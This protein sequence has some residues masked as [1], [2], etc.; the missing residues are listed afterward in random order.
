M[1]DQFLKRGK[2]PSLDGWRALSV[3]FV[4]VAH[5]RIDG[6][7]TS[8]YYYFGVTGVR[9]FFVISGFLITWLLLREEGSK[10]R[11]SLGSFYLRRAFRILPVY[12]VFLIV[13]FV[14]ERLVFPTQSTSIYQWLASLTFTANY[15]EARGIT[16]HLWTLSVEEQ[17]YLLWPLAFILIRS[18]RS[19]VVILTSIIIAAPVLRAL[20]Y[21][22]AKDS[23]QPF[24]FHRFSFLFHND[25]LSWGC[26]SAMILWHRPNLWQ[27][28]RDVG[29]FLPITGLLLIT[30]PLLINSV[31]ET[32]WISV[33]FNATF[34]AVGFTSVMLSS[35]VLSK[36]HAFSFLNWPI[37]I[38]FGT[39]SYS[40]YLWHMLFTPEILAPYGW[41]PET[42]P[43]R[44]IWV[45]PA[46]L[47][48]VI[49]YYSLEKTFMACRKR[50]S[51]HD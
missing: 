2:I 19:R 25:I 41:V 33:P 7:S 13:A 35:I 12:Y 39:I 45:I 46:I 48:S 30:S 51:T 3:L 28:I 11:I 18:Q 27:K 31:S 47:C 44:F 49:S 32:T 40:L 8:L 16:G 42:Y 21:V 29:L 50:Y 34:Q 26:L 6:E 17:F 9:F 4:L 5:S 38:W 22:L 15:S 14:S 37:V 10:G 1:N 36:R 23:I 24:I 43:A 20:G